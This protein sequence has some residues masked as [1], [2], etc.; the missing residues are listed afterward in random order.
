MPLTVTRRSI[1]ALQPAPASLRGARP[2]GYFAGHT[3]PSAR[4]HARDGLSAVALPNAGTTATQQTPQRL[5]GLAD[6]SS[7][8]PAA[9]WHTCQVCPSRA[10]S[11]SSPCWWDGSLQVN[12]AA[13]CSGK[14]EGSGGPMHGLCYNWLG[15][16]MPPVPWR[17]QLALAEQYSSLC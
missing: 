1:G 7:T 15:T 6:D 5:L 13:G 10:L 14:M 16:V 11:Y 9:L 3:V 4:R 2:P 8:V 12:G 17:R